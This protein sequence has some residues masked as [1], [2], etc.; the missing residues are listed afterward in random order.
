VSDLAPGDLLDQYRIT[1]PI[2]LGATSSIFEAV[3]TTSGAPVSLKV[4]HDAYAGDPIFHANVVRE[5]RIGRRLEHPNVVKMLTPA[6]K[7][8]PYLVTEYVEG[9]PLRSLLQANRPLEPARA[10]D[11]ARQI[12]ETLVYLHG[13]G[14]IHRDLKPENVMVMPDGH[15]KIVDFGIALDRPRRGFEWLGST[16]MGTPDYMAPEQARGL[17]GDERSDIAALGVILYEMLTGALP[18]PGDGPFAVMRSKLGSDPIPPTRFRPD[19]APELEEIILHAIER[20]PRRRYRT[21]AELLADLRAPERVRP[22]G[23]AARLRPRSLEA[24]LARRIAVWVAA[25]LGVLVALVVLVWLANRFPV[26][27]TGR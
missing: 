25:G 3:D 26:P 18:Y 6:H 20:A 11:I 5:E 4:P 27:P 15:L 12:A 7:S 21:A 16:P 23:R 19:L 13:Q 1:R 14:V 2:A 8:R 10:L 9:V 22:Q 24:Q 17:R